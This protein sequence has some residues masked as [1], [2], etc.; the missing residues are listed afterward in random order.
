MVMP[1]KKDTIN[2]EG[3]QVAKRHLLYSSRETYEKFKKLYPEFPQKFVTF[4]G[5][6]PRNFNRLD[7]T[8]TCRRVCVCIKHYNLE[9]KI[10]SLNE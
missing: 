10:E 4:L 5:M 1:N 7:L 6:I 8:V 3:E 9:H 2:I